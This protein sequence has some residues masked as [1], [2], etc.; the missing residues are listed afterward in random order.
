MPEN[1]LLNSL[2]ADL[3]KALDSRSEV[4]HLPIK[5]YVM[6]PGEP[7]SH[8]YFPLTGL[9]SI[10]VTLED[11]GTVETL[12]IANEGFAG[13]PLVLGQLI[14]TREG[15]V[16]IA[17]D[18]LRITTA[19]FLDVLGEDSRLQSSLQAYIHYAMRVIEQSAAC[20]AFHALE[21][22]LARWLLSVNDRLPGDVPLTH[23]FL[24]QM[25]GVYRPSVTLA[26]G[27]LQEAGL[28]ANRRGVIQI[29]NRESL[30]AAACECYKATRV[31][32]KTEA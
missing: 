16:Q 28:I 30:E 2:P 24:S 9:I 1:L 14:G 29:I 23:E 18:F 8:V 4:V 27:M 25:L 20:L 3:K 13:I 12:T 11:G 32:P 31:W 7:I 6:R 5:S 21:A 26:I 22:R 15:F 17:G 10:V 19:D